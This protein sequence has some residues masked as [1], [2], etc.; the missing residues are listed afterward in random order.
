MFLT[1]SLSSLANRINFFKVASLFRY[2]KIKSGSILFIFKYNNFFEKSDKFGVKVS[3]LNVKKLR[4]GRTSLTFLRVLKRAAKDAYLKFTRKTEV[5]YNILSN[6]AEKNNKIAD[7]GASSMGK[8]DGFLPLIYRRS[9][10]FH[11]YS[12]RAVGLKNITKPVY[13]LSA[14]GPSFRMRFFLRSHLFLSRVVAFARRFHS[15]KN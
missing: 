3:S 14:F 11:I 1:S 5:Q 9:P 10:N 13:S 15:K 2:Y 6:D 7:F 12:V 8:E 4:E